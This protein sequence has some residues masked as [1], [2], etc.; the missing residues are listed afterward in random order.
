MCFICDSSVLEIYEV[1][2]LSSLNCW[3]ANEFLYKG[4]LLPYKQSNVFLPLL[5]CYDN[6][7]K[8]DITIIDVNKVTKTVD[9]SSVLLNFVRNFFLY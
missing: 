8:I 1:S 5:H 4:I 6:F 9:L 3:S 7:F 2:F